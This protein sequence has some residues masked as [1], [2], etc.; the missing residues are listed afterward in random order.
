VVQQLGHRIRLPKIVEAA[1][2][3]QR[4]YTVTIEH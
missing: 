1:A 3:A 4:G 2:V